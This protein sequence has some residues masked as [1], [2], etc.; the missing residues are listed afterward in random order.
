MLTSGDVVDLDLGIPQGREAGFRHPAIVVTG[1]RMLNL[2]PPVIQIVPT[3][4]TLRPGE[5]EIRIEPD[6][7]NGLEVESS[8]Q[9]EQVR[10]VSTSRIALVRGNVG[11]V[12]LAQV[13][14]RLA[15]L[16]DIP[17]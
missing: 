9:C 1:Q 16:L 6:R 8:V 11:P 13:R 2:G 14:E 17:G 5:F 10:G 7:S 12:V 4:S 15:V 3:T